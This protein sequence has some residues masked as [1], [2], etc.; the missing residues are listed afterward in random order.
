MNVH[1]KRPE[2]ERF[3]NECVKE[4]AFPSHDDAVEA[5]V[6]QM[7]LDWEFEVTDEDVQAIE[8]GEAQLDRGEGRPWEELRAELLARHPPK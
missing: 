6:E 2:L 1:L 7:K 3:I 4:G 8:E 5:A